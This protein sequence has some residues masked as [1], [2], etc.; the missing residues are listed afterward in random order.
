MVA[1]GLPREHAFGA[2]FDIVETRW[3]QVSEMPAHPSSNRMANCNAPAN[4]Q[5]AGSSVLHLQAHRGGAHTT[6]DWY[7]VIARDVVD[8]A[9]SAAAAAASAADAAA[10]C[11]LLLLLML[12]LLLLLR[13]LLLLLALLLYDSRA[14][15]PHPI[16]GDAFPDIGEKPSVYIYIYI[17]TYIWE[18]PHILRHTNIQ[19]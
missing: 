9:A 11:P 14:G 4:H 13:S 17:S 19:E 8:K 3:W 5:L 10:S 16:H 18:F 7:A 6:T 2:L 12:L 1:C 15:V